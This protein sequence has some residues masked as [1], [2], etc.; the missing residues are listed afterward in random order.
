MTDREKL[1]K[2][3][4]NSMDEWHEHSLDICEA[5][6]ILGEY[7]REEYIAEYLIAHGVT[8]QGWISVED[9]LP[10]VNTDVWCYSDKWGGYFFVGWINPNTGRWRDV[11]GEAHIGTVTHWMPFPEPPKEEA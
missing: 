4:I 1:T 11:T 6:G 8:V 9:R 7:D 3:I 5:G 10:E 2:L